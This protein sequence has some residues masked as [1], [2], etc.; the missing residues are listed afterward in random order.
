MVGP[1]P[2]QCARHQGWDAARFSVN[3]GFAAGAHENAA[4]T[5]RAGGGLPCVTCRESI[6]MAGVGH[7]RLG[8]GEISLRGDTMGIRTFAAILCGLALGAGQAAAQAPGNCEVTGLEGQHARLQLGD[9]WLPV[10]PGAMP[11]QASTVETGAATR[12]EISCAGGFV[13]TL[14][15]DS[16]ADLAEL[17]G[18]PDAEPGIVMLLISGIIGVVTPD[19]LAE[20][21]EVRTPAVIAAVRSTKWLVEHDPAAGAS[22]VFVRRGRVTVS[23]REIA[24]VLDPGEG[25]T[26]TRNSTVKPVASWGQARIDQS[27]GALGFGWQ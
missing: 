8:P 13:V 20:P 17:V 25:I 16:R 12:L 24:V 9:G 21:V 19:R 3:A 1:P 14:G 15:P 4:G 2:S 11:A 26:L 6:A 22:A 18:P 10:E 27:T 7:P 23:N 5:R